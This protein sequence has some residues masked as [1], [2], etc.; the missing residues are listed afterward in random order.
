MI[1]NCQGVRDNAM[2]T[3][4]DWSNS[5]LF[6]VPDTQH[7]FFY[8]CY[9]GCA[10]Y[11]QLKRAKPPHSDQCSKWGGTPKEENKVLKKS[12]L[13][14]LKAVV[15]IVDQVPRRQGVHFEQLCVA[16]GGKIG[17]PLR[18]NC[19]GDFECV[20]PGRHW[21]NQYQTYGFTPKCEGC[22]CRKPTEPVHVDSEPG[23]GGGGKE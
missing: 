21:S 2:P 15:T 10:Q 5:S 19:K 20:G 9:Q 7:S 16:S 17:V 23:G 6:P 22:T 8:A 1:N 14:V 4:G 3:H 13:H 12:G 11:V 18:C